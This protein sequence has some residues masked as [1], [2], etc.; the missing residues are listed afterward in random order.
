M[1][2]SGSGRDAAE[3]DRIRRVP[4]RSPAAGI[5]VGVAALVLGARRAGIVWVPLAFLIVGALVAS[6]WAW[7]GLR[8]RRLRRAHP[9]WHLV[10]AGTA[11]EPDGSIGPP[12]SFYGVA[13]FMMLIFPRDHEIWRWNVLKPARRISGI[14]FLVSALICVAI[15]AARRR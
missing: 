6:M 13:T 12:A 5:C 3:V 9:E 11:R 15:L 7:A 10:V 14:V 2:G 8:D 1:Q 4:G